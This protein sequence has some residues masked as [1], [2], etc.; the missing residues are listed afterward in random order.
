M[1]STRSHEERRANAHQWLLNRIHRIQPD[2]LDFFVTEAAEQFQSDTEEVRS[3]IIDVLNDMDC[4]PDDDDD[5]FC[6]DFADPGGN[7]ALRAASPT[8]PRIHA[9]PTCGNENVL[10]TEDV[11]LGYQCDACAD[12]AERG[13]D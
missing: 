6:I 1:S 12:R 9:C 13:Y 4:S 7:S 3:D 2:N 5:D 11:R 8:N 10:T